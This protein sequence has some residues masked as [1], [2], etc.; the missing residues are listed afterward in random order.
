MGKLSYQLLFPNVDV[1]DLSCNQFRVPI[2]LWSTNA[3]KLSL[4]S[5][6]FPGPISSTISDLMPRQWCNLPS[7]YIL[8][9]A[10]NNL[11]GDILDCLE[12]LTGRIS[13]GNQLQTL[14]NVSI[15]EG[16]PSL[17][18]SPLSTRCLGDE[19]FDSTTFVDDSVEDKHDRFDIE[20][21]R[22]GSIVGLLVKKS[23]GR[24]IKDRI[25]LKYGL[26]KN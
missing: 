25:S 8:D 5:N 1:V 2:P 20:S 15:C 24:D 6:S 19:K 23:W 10:Q 22:L 14:N 21:I 4:K 11:F 16:N 26:E 12:N 3:T 17:C 18:G 7:L 13:Y 9:L